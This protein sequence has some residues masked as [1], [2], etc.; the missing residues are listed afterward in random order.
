[1]DAQR[2]EEQ[3]SELKKLESNIGNYKDIKGRLEDREACRQRLG[4]K[5]VP[6]KTKQ[7]IDEERKTQIID[8]LT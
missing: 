8:N 2:K 5:D 4:Y 3:F 1:M 6:G 7:V